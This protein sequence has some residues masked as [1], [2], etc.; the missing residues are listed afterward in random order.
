MWPY[1]YD[2]KAQGLVNMENDNDIKFTLVQDV[3][4]LP[5]I[6]SKHSD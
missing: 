4:I 1:I 2:A 5:I 3:K 6:N